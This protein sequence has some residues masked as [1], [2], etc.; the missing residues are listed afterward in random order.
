MSEPRPAG[1]AYLSWIPFRSTGTRCRWMRH[2]NWHP[3]G[4]YW[5]IRAVTKATGSIP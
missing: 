5:T 4:E 1:G 3:T 2:P